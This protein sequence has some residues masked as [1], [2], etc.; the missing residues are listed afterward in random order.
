MGIL[1]VVYSYAPVWGSTQRVFVSAMDS[2][3]S[4]QLKESQFL[5]SDAEQMLLKEVEI[6][7]Y[8]RWV[9]KVQGKEFLVHFLEGRDL[10]KSFEV[11]RNKIKEG[12]PEALEFQAF[13]HS[14][15]DLDLD[16]IPIPSELT[17][18]LHVDI[19]GENAIKKEYCFCYPILPAKKDKLLKLFEKKSEYFDQR[20]QDAYAY[21]GIGKQKLWLQE[22]GSELFLV[23]Y[24][25]IV[26]PVT[27]ARER[28]LT[29]KT[30]EFSKRRS[31]K[32]SEITGLSYEELLPHLESLSDHEILN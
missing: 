21:R 23:I 20:A 29:Q 10:E 26:G 15:L 28:Y 17:E 30:E 12:I 32:M 22:I 27:D 24:Q 25:E 31:K 11:L 9:Q 1:W 13:C 3:Q 2:N 4:H 19:D 16:N 5:G 6:E 8:L 18:L 14:T 7:K